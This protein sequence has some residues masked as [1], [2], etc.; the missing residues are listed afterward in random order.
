[1]QPTYIISVQPEQQPDD[2]DGIRRLRELLKRLLRSFGFAAFP[3]PNKIQ[4]SL[5]PRPRP[6]LRRHRQRPI[7]ERFF[8][9]MSEAF[10]SDFL[11]CSD[12]KDREVVATMSSLQKESFGSGKDKEEKH[13]LGFANSKKRLIL[14]KTNW[15]AIEALYGDSDSWMGKQIVLYPSRTQF[16]N[17]IVDCIRVK[18]TQPVTIAAPAAAATTADAANAEFQKAANS[19]PPSDDIPF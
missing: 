7:S 14:N 1:M 2:A 19:V 18:P 15:G 13:V 17:K 12:L 3:L 8:M 5:T 11:K 16:G 4:N 9:K 6:A 10:P